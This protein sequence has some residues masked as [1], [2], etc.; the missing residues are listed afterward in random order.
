MAAR[1]DRTGVTAGR[2]RPGPTDDARRFR[3]DRGDALSV[4]QLPA[5]ATVH[6]R[7]QRRRGDVGDLTRVARDLLLP[8]LAGVFACA[9]DVHERAVFFGLALGTRAAI[10][11][12]LCCPGRTGR[13]LR[14]DALA[15]RDLRADSGV[16]R[17]HL[18][19]AGGQ[20]TPGAVGRVRRV[21]GRLLAADG[22]L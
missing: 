3:R 7:R 15:G 1:G 10:D 5:R 11:P 20:T 9:L 8:G 12:W 4:D 21:D 16:R 22:R 2:L 13:A 18:A 6:R 17:A 19:R 14:V